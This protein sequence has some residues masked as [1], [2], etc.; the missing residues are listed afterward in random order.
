[1]AQLF[2]LFWKKGIKADV[3]VIPFNDAIIVHI[4]LDSIDQYGKQGFPQKS[5]S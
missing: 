2:L 1:M 3:W 4:G 5:I